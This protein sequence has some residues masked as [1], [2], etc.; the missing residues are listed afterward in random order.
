MKMTRLLQSCI[1]V[2]FVFILMVL[3]RPWVAS[4]ETGVHYPP[5]Y[6]SNR[7][8]EDYSYLRN[9]AL[10]T[11]VWDP[12]KYIPFN[13]S[14][15]WYLSLGGEVRERY[16][17][18]SHPQWGAGPPG[19]GYLLQRYFLHAD[20]HMGDH[21]R[22]FNQLQSSF[23]NGR[24]GGPRPVDKDELDLHQSFL[25]I[26]VNLGGDG[27]FV[28]RSG[29]Q[30]L[31][32]GSSRI[33]AVREGPNVR[34]NFDGFRAMFRKRDIKIDAFA[35]KLV[36]NKR[37]VFDDSTDN[38]H[39]LWGVYSVLPLP[40]IAKGNIDLYYIG[41]YNREM[42]FDQ[43][44]AR[45]IRHSVGTRLWRTAKPL[46]YDFEFTYQWGVFGH[47]NIQAWTVASDTGYTFKGLPLHP[48]LGLKANITS[49]DR[50]PN[51][52]DLQTFNPL[53]PKAAYFSLNGLMGPLNHIDLNPLVRLHF[54]GG[55]SLTM[56]WDFFWREST[57]DG[58]YA[59][60]LAL[61]R[62]GKKSSA[63]YV[64]NQPQAV[65]RWGIERHIT[66]VAM[67]AHFSAGTFFK[68]TGPAKDVDW[69]TTWLTYKF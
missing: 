32:Y 66:F 27:L 20:L 40:V 60:S 28:L 59:N 18:F 68:E 21:L 54:T 15:A 30:E 22:I 33:I 49:G 6:T 42:R 26:K 45:E 65:L 55:F 41:Y 50:D 7:A 47:G 56:N 2:F 3:I 10:R 69:M 43:G 8:D 46:D 63:R 44:R 53:F 19:S 62:S 16:E 9:P 37:Y 48:R 39:G 17:Y 14:G 29:R 35:A 24:D 57:H 51:N 31:S 1:G 25:E 58:V 67:Y 4:A 34:R 64:G 23:E 13:E 5:A 61:V 38:S 36:E 52:P 12:I 11:D